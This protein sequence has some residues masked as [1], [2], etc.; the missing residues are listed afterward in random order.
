MHRRKQ[1][2][3]FRH[4][5]TDRYSREAALLAGLRRVDEASAAF[6][7]GRAHLSSGPSVP[8]E[9]EV[10]AQWR[11]RRADPTSENH[12]LPP[13][14]LS[15]SQGVLGNVEA[16]RVLNQETRRRA[17]ARGNQALLNGALRSL[18][19]LHMQTGRLELM[20]RL[21]ELQGR[22]AAAERYDRK[23]VSVVEAYRASLTASQWSMTAFGEWREMARGPPGLVRTLLAQDRKRAAL[24]ALDRSRTNAMHFDLRPLRTLYETV[25]APITEHLPAQQPLT[26]VP[27]G[28]LFRIPF[29]MLVG[30]M[31][32]GRFAPAEARYVLHERPRGP[33][34]RTGRPRRPPSR[35]GPALVG[36][37]PAARAVLQRR[38]PRLK[39]GTGPGLSGPLDARGGGSF[40]GGAPP[41][42][43]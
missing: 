24:T 3:N 41:R 4:V 27:D 14:F 36:P 26:V 20:G 22:W 43:T 8:H 32:G 5:F 33:L 29:S 25:Y 28:P 17:R 10:P 1:K 2:T 16:A 18:G 39:R 23:G 34:G 15:Q 31:P 9:E 38:A 35:L 37:R 30:A 21:H 42:S 40:V 12:L 13:L 7:R 11:R 6:E 19:Q